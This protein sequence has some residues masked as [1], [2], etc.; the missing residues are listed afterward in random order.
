M[1][2][3]D[4]IWLTGTV[5]FYLETHLAYLYQDIWN[6]VKSTGKAEVVVSKDH[7]RTLIQGVRRTKSYEN[8]LKRRVGKVRW[9]KM[10]TEVKELG[11][12]KVKV[13]FTLSYETRL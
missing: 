13:T 5:L 2:Q 1:E 3:K 8:G 10:W 6:A 7:A 11:Q 4:C 12:G 9:A